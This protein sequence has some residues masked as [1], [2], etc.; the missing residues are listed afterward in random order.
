LK[1]KIIIIIILITNNNL[2]K[3]TYNINQIKKNGS[4]FEIY[5][6]P[7]TNLPERPKFSGGLVK[8]LFHPTPKQ[9]HI[10]FG[11]EDDD[12]FETP[13]TPLI[14]K[15]L[16]NP[17]VEGKSHFLL[18]LSFFLFLFFFLLFF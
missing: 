7:K 16:E 14:I 4:R 10:L 11:V 15:L 1:K 5:L 8:L 12:L 2:E 6:N 18:L 13:L 3:L 17:F 9:N